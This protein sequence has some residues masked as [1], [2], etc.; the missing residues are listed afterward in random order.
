MT[1]ETKLT[2]WYATIRA[3]PAG[4]APE[5]TR[6]QN[7][8]PRATMPP[9]AAATMTASMERRPSSAQ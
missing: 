5:I 7:G 2:P 9:S 4:S 6:P 8:A 3:P 1:A